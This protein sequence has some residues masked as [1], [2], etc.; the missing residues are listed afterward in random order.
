MSNIFEL[1]LAT[2]KINSL[3]ELNT[4]MAS[5]FD[6]LGFDKYAYVLVNNPNDIKMN[7]SYVSN[8]PTQW[9]ERYTAQ[10]YFTVDPL[11]ELF[12]KSN[13]LFSWSWDQQ[14]ENLSPIQKKFFWEAN[15]FGV[16]AGVGIPILSPNGGFSIVS[17]CSKYIDEKE[18]EKYSK[19]K[20]KDLIIASLIHHQATLALKTK[21][22]KYQDFRL[23]DRELETLYWL[24]QGKTNYEIAMILGLK[25]EGIVQ[26]LRSIYTKMN[27]H[28]RVDAVKIALQAGLLSI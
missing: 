12:K 8:Y 4:L 15:D 1:M 6:N 28:G 5:Y 9:E 18:I 13:K 24:S 17:L 16:D 26:R 20:E 21:V 25:R 11:Y 27:V 7:N 22:Q 23:T 19:E 10:N 14:K 2:H 3:D